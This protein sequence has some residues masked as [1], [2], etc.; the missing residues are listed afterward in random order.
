[1]GV[2]WFVA[3]PLINILRH[4]ILIILKNEFL[5][6]LSK[7]ELEETLKT[8]RHYTMALQE[9]HFQ[10]LRDRVAQSALIWASIDGL[11]DST[12]ISVF[13]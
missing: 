4:T 5:K 3:A 6:D 9:S 8:D 1:M 7:I 11:P 2:I 12:G 10:Y 13:L